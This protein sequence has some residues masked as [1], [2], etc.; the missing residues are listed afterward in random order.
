[1]SLKIKLSRFGRK[2]NPRYRIVVMER[3][4]R[5]DGKYI[6]LIGTYNPIP[7]PH[8][9]DIDDK[10]LFEWIQKGAQLTDGTSKLLKKRIA[11]YEGIS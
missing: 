9:I 11:K 8:T 7:D 6:D 5:R 4:M 2:N 3:S 10:K 1:M